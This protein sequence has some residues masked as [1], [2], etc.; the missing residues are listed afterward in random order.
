MDE[1]YLEI[2]TGP[3][4]RLQGIEQEDPSLELKENLWPRRDQKLQG[5]SK[6]NDARATSELL[7]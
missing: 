3:L 2:E 6:W 5:K 4:D 7:L 1:D